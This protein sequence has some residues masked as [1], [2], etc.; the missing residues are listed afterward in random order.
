MNNIKKKGYHREHIYPNESF[1]QESIEKHF[2]SKGFDIE[3]KPNVDLSCVH[4]ESR[5]SWMIEAK[6]QSKS[7]G[8]DFKTA[9]GQIIFRMDNNDY[10]YGIAVPNTKQYLSQINK[11]P[12]LVIERLRLVFFVVSEDGSVSTL[13]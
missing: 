10:K 2:I 8:V 6:G 12:D 11:V 4:P 7:I 5:E 9:I 3:N 1:V 13:N